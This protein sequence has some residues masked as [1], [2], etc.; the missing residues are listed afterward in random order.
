[1]YLCNRKPAKSPYYSEI[2]SWA[3]HLKYSNLENKAIT[4]ILTEDYVFLSLE[5]SIFIML[6]IL[7]NV[8]LSSK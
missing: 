2:F 1:M 7:I 8:T 6:I 5:I 3:I 4:S